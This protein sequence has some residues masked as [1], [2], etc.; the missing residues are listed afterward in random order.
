MFGDLVSLSGFFVNNR[1]RV[2]CSFVQA[3][4]LNVL[5]FLSDIQLRN[6]FIACFIRTCFFYKKL[7]CFEDYGS[8]QAQI[9]GTF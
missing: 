4:E 3:K 1:Y 8:D 2:V 7:S 6:Y 9:L 5:L